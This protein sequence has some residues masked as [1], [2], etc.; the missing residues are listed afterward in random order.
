MSEE[1]SHPNDWLFLP[2]VTLNLWTWNTLKQSL[3]KASPLVSPGQVTISM[4]R[5]RYTQLSAGPSAGH[6]MPNNQQD[7]STAPLIKREDAYSHT[8]LTDTSNHTTWHHPSHKRN[9]QHYPPECR[10][11]S[12]PP[13]GYTIPWTN[14]TNEGANNR[15]KWKGDHKQ[16]K[17]NKMI[18]KRNML[19]MKKQGKNPQDQ[20][21][22][23]KIGNRLENNSQ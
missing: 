19:Q 8:K 14:L 3:Q 11:L 1:P 22:E 16:T 4:L 20:I 23:E 6:L 21:N 10:L 2:I 17:L 9:T 12:L 18:Q 5:P 15:S 13:G 7:S